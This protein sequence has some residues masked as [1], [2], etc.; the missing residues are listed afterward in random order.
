MRCLPLRRAFYE[1]LEKQA[2]K[3]PVLTGELNTEFTGC[4]IV[5][6]ALVFVL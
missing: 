3:L 6:V 2:D 4:Y 5:M 1:R